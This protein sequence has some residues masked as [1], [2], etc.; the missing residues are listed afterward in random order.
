[1]KKNLVHFKFRNNMSLYVL[2][3]L[4]G[5]RGLDRSLLDP[6]P[7][8]MDGVGTGTGIDG[9]RGLNR[10]LLDPRPMGMDG[11]GTGT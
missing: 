3:V 4:D 11:G 10:S 9:A 8:G 1:M 2:F 5:A 6:R 7:L